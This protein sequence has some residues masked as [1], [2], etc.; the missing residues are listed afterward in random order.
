[1]DII[2]NWVINSVRSYRH[3]VLVVVYEDLKSDEDMHVQRM[4]NFLNM[5]EGVD[6]KTDNLAVTRPSR[7]FT[8]SFHR[9]RSGTEESFE[10]YTGPQKTHVLDIITQTQKRLEKHNL[11][12][13]L[14]VSRYLEKYESKTFLGKLHENDEK[15]RT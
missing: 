10:H 11:T 6:N 7:N 2:D 15:F 12:S 13:V 4:V 8:R 5:V 3:R 1:M 14:D 9:K